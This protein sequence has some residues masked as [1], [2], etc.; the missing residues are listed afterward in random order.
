[1][2]EKDKESKGQAKEHPLE[3]AYRIQADKM[4]KDAVGKGTVGAQGKKHELLRGETYQAM[5]KAG[6]R[7]QL[8]KRYRIG[9]TNPGKGR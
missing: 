6:L 4:A 5:V 2:A 7:L 9:R 1:M 3:A 8:P